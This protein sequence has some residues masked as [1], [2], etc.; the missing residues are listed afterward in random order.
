MSD[1][2]YSIQQASVLVDGFKIINIQIDINNQKARIS[3][4]LF[5]QDVFV[6][7]KYLTMEG[8]DYSSWGNQDIPFVINWI[9]VKLNFTIAN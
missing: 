5:Y 1:K 7:A 2:L 6:C 9:C 8:E 4:E 3:V